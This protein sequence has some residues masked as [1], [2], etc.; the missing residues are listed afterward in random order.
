MNEDLNDKIK[1]YEITKKGLFAKY[2]AQKEFEKIKDKVNIINITAYY[3]FRNPL[4]LFNNEYKIV[5][6]NKN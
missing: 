2:R 1:T 3:D 4:N 5:Y 6:K